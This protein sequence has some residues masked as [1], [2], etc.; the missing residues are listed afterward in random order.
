[1]PALDGA[2]S[3]VVRVALAAR[4]WCGVLTGVR[5]AE[6]DGPEDVEA[7]GP[8]GV[9]ALDGARART[10]VALVAVVARARGRGVVMVAVL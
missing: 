4:C 3:S 7:V 5:G 6:V 1:M 8:C 10:F 9:P 2:G